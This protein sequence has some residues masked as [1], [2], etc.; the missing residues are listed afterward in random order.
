MSLQHILLGLLETPA[1]GYDIKQEFDKSLSFFWS[2]NL[3][4]VYPTLK[5]LLNKGLVESW[6]ESSDI[7]P[8]RVVYKRTTAGGKRLK[9]WLNEGPKVET[10][11]RHY[12]AQLFFLHNAPDDERE[13]FLMKLHDEMS[14]R[15]ELIQKTECV[16]VEKFGPDYPDNLPS[17]EF[18]RHMVFDLG[19]DVFKL[20]SS[21]TLKCLERLSD[22]KQSE[23]VVFEP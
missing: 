23:K 2:A 6:S 12:L 14:L 21:W 19:Q 8:D 4:Q 17:D 13:S 5:K 10:E 7:G 20:Y 3:A 15:E 16:W 9:S 1:S 18:F 22:R 11:K